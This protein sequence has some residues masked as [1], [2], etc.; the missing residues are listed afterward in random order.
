LNLNLSTNDGKVLDL[1][2]ALEA[3]MKAIKDSN[4]KTKK[5]SKLKK[6]A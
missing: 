3:S 4:S 1:M 2:A 5:K 6:E